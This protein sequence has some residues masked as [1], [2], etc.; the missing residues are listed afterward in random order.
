MEPITTKE[1]SEGITQKTDNHINY[2]IKNNRKITLDTFEWREFET[3]LIQ[4]SNRIKYSFKKND[5]D[6]SLSK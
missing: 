3:F 5:L 1:L 2:F 4:A 6:E